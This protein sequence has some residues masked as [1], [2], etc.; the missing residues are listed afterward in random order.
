MFS[1]L[2]KCDSDKREL[3]YVFT[4]MGCQW[5]GM[6]KDMMQIKAFS[7]SI[8]RTNTYLR[9]FHIDLHSMIMSD[10]ANVFKNTVNT[11]VA[12]AGIQVG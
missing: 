3:W 12:I 2:Q 1:T 8:M 9:E 10:D 7:D 4:G 6:A 5:T 11:F